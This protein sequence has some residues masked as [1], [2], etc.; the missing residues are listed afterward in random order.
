M[1][2]VVLSYCLLL[3]CFVLL[4]GLRKNEEE[5]SFLLLVLAPDSAFGLVKSKR[6][7]LSQQVVMELIGA[8]TFSL[9]LVVR[10]YDKDPLIIEGARCMRE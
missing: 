6:Q 9:H 10:G 7:G 4:G 2:G 8:C 5:S 3:F 1:T